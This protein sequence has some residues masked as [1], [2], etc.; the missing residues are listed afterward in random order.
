MRVIFIKNSTLYKTAAVILAIIILLTAFFL[1]N[2][3]KA[4][5]TF[6][7]KGDVFYKGNVDE[8][9]IAFTCN[10]D[11]G[12]EHIPAML[13]IFKE[14]D[15]KITF[16]VTGRWAEKNQDLLKEIHA[17]G[18]EIGNHGYSHK[19]YSK[20]DYSLNKTQIS[21]A[22]GVIESS[23]SIKPKFFAPPSGAYNKDTVR[24][25][26]DLNY[27]VIMWSIDTIDW[28]KDS[29]YDKIVNRV[30]S[31]TEN[32]AIVLMHPKEETI[33]ALPTIIKTL[34]EQG[35]RIGKVSD[36]VR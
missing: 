21:R 32:S 34:E 31:K 29:S 16:F 6:N 28:R 35:Y 30:V 22:H 11:W 7:E 12:N 15:I 14:N 27:H 33:K 9:I 3:D 10:V 8:N 5:E 24:A 25:A 1:I 20:L 2:K 17:Q 13:H 4:R 19:D 18:H 23:L 26:N 36:I